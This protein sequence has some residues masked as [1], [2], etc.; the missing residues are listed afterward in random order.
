MMH[1]LRCIALLDYTLSKLY[2]GQRMQVPVSRVDEAQ[3]N[4]IQLSK[5]LKNQ[6]VEVQAKIRDVLEAL[7]TVQTVQGLLYLTN[8]MKQAIT[9][10]LADLQNTLRLEAF[11]FFKVNEFEP[12]AQTIPVMRKIV[13]AALDAGRI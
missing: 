11:E 3:S 9:S 10:G 2:N 12:N 5:I 13:Q 1:Y 6:S 8:E 7:Q 4:V